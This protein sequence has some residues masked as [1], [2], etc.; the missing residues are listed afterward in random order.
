ME[1]YC[2]RKARVL[3]GA[4][5]ASVNAAAYR[6]KY[7]QSSAW[8]RLRVNTDA[9]K[10]AVE[11]V[12]D[13]YNSAVKNLYPAIYLEYNKIVST[14]VGGATAG[15]TGNNNPGAVNRFIRVEPGKSYTIS[16]FFGGLGSGTA[17]KYVLMSNG[18]LSD[19]FAGTRNVV[20]GIRTLTNFGTT[21]RPIYSFTVPTV[22][23][24]GTAIT[25]MAIQ[26]VYLA[27]IDPYDPEDP[28]N[29]SF[30]VID[31]MMIEEGG[32][33]TYWC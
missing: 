10:L 15:G 33:L 24:A 21:D 16:G 28:A 3:P 11:Y 12:R 29:D 6:K 23:E 32:I 4:T 22:L 30:A 20:G 2:C 7:L 9:T 13:T 17:P 14:T 18:G 19:P 25:S 26:V 27:G 5:Q 8:S 31:K 1:W